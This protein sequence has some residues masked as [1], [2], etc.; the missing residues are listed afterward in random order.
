M[1]VVFSST[2][3]V[4]FCSVFVICQYLHA[5]RP[6]GRQ[7]ARQNSYDVVQWFLY[8]YIVSASLWMWVC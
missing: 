6:S 8:V 7:G 2:Y 1:L 3:A 4:K 5:G